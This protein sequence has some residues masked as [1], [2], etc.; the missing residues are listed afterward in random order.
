MF[1]GP[2][3]G[4]AGPTAKQRLTCYLQSALALVSVPVSI[5]DA[6][7]MSFVLARDCNGP[8]RRMATAPSFAWKIA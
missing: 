8:S 1:C 2:L 6:E 5:T 4:H 3:R 7:Q